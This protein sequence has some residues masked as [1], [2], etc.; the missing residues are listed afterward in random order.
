MAPFRFRLETVQRL[1]AHAERRAKE[2]LARAIVEREQR[3]HALV[4]SRRALEHAYTT[5]QPDDPVARACAE[6]LIVRR[7]RER[8]DAERALAA[9]EVEVGLS[10]V[11]AVEAARASEIVARLEA[12]HRAAH[13][14]EALREED[15]T[16]S[17]LALTLHR[18]R[19]I[20]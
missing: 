2:E 1:R 7:E 14:R 16:L 19:S 9:Q 5:A 20:T 4:R 13:R 3:A 18:R 15:A 6:A 11:D 10:R 8:S 12:R 17:E